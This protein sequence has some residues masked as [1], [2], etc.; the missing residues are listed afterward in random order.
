[1]SERVAFMATTVLGM[2]ETGLKRYT[3]N[4]SG[5]NQ[6]RTVSKNHTT[7]GHDLLIATT[8]MKFQPLPRIRPSERD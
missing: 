8:K 2:H 7:G 4:A 3:C 1:M 5:T 6:D